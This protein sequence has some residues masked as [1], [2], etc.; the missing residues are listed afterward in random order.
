[1]S[2]QQHRREAPRRVPVAVLTVSDTRTPDT[3]TAGALIRRL[4]A[5][6]G[7]PVVDSAIVP[8]VTARVRRVLRRWAGDRC[9][10]AVILTGGTGISP[11]DRTFEAVEELLEKR[12]EGFGEIFRMLSYRQV[13]PAAILS[14][15]VA[16]TWRGRLLFSLPGSER[17]VRLAMEKI[18]LPELGHLAY[19]VSR[20]PAQSRRGVPRRS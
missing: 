1:M 17:A 20:S 7:H 10:R 19:E 6:A 15:A 13:G 3:D 11:R 9:I 5:R 2:H 18:I 14:R 8:D 16:G 4:L 12:L